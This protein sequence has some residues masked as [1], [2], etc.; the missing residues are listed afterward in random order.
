[1]AD[2]HA[3][4][5]DEG[6]DLHDDREIEV[7]GILRVVAIL[8]VVTVASLGMMWFFAGSLRSEERAGHA[9]PPPIATSRPAA[10]AAPRLQPHPPEGLAE[11]RAQEEDILS[12]YR[13]IDPGHTTVGMPIDRAIDLVLEHPPPARSATGPVGEP[14]SSR[15]TQSSLGEHGGEP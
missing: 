11:L 5:L 1:M 9:E 8:V 4:K 15:P 12:T 7:R 10:P 13:W 14:P 6:P 2:R 3:R